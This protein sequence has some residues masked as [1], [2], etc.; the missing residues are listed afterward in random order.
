[1]LVKQVEQLKIIAAVDEFER[2]PFIYLSTVSKK[3]KNCSGRF[4]LV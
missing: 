3:L 1:M 2:E 4:V